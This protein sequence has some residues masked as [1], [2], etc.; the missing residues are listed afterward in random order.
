MNPA[1]KHPRTPGSKDGSL[2][3][4]SH[5]SRLPTAP[6]EIGPE[7]VIPLTA[8]AHT[9]LNQRTHVPGPILLSARHRNLSRR[10]RDHPS[11]ARVRRHG[12]HFRIVFDP[13][14]AVAV[15]AVLVCGAEGA[16]GAR[17]CQGRVAASLLVFV[18]L[19]DVDA[20]ADGHTDGTPVVAAGAG[21]ARHR[22]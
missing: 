15:E 10:S 5:R 6:R 12:A 2:R 18:A 11:G 3:G 21:D 4:K 16:L 14:A 22:W 8:R 13:L 19:V 7:L 1:K 17:G 9:T 20:H